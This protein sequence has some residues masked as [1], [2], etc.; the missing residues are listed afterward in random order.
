MQGETVRGEEGSWG[1]KIRRQVFSLN[2]ISV[3]KYEVYRRVLKIVKLGCYFLV[4][5]S[6]F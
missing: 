3:L 6:I 5:E 2:H 4:P 1:Q